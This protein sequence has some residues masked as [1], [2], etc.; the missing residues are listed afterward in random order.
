MVLLFILVRKFRLAVAV[1]CKSSPIDLGVSGA[2]GVSADAIGALGGLLGVFEGY[3][4]VLVDL[5][6]VLGEHSFGS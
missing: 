6:D 5:V 1:I 3:V 2:S 4:Q